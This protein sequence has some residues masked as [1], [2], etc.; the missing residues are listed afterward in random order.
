MKPPRPGS[1][2]WN[3]K[4][5]HGRIERDDPE[6]HDPNSHA[7]DSHDPNSQRTRVGPP[8]PVGAAARHRR[9]AGGRTPGGRADG[10]VAGNR[11]TARR[12]RNRADRWTR[13]AAG[14]SP[15]FS[16]RHDREEGMGTVLDAADVRIGRRLR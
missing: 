4:V 14:R 6:S 3:L 9:G 1:H 7:P 12:P 8:T 5:G 11:P 16:G 15:V 2:L 13:R 10:P